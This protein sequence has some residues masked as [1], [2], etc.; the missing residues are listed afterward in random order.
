SCARGHP[1]AESQL[2]A[3]RARSRRMV[4]IDEGLRARAEREAACAGLFRAPSRSPEDPRP[5]PLVIHGPEY[6]RP[7]RL[8]FLLMIAA[9]P[10]TLMLVTTLAADATF[11]VDMR[12]QAPTVAIDVQSVGP[13]V[14]ERVP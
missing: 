9:L 2:R 12:A 7:L 10:R 1:V 3:S 8:F 13:K 4:C 6:F 11:A 5:P 14:G